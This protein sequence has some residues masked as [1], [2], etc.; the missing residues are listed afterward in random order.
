MKKTYIC[1]TITVDMTQAIG[2]ICSSVTPP[3]EIP[4]YDDWMGVKEND[5]STGSD[6]IWD[7]EW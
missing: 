5:G 3:N 6:N 4:D 2:I 7:E 1:P